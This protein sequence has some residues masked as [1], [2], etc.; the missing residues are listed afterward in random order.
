VVCHGYPAVAEGLV[1]IERVGIVASNVS[2]P[3]VDGVREYAVE[4]DDNAVLR[5]ADIDVLPGRT[6]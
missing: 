6:P 1:A 4:F 3:A 2:V 5:V